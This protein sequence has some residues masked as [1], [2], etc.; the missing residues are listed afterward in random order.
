M[1]R[2]WKCQVQMVWL[3][4][5]SYPFF[6]TTYIDSQRI[7]L[8]LDARSVICI[9]PTCCPTISHPTLPMRSLSSSSIKSRTRMECSLHCPSCMENSLLGPGFTLD[10]HQQEQEPA[11]LGFQGLFPL[12]CI[13][14]LIL[15]TYT[16]TGLSCQCR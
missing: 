5:R 11:I 16:S 4:V 3:Q 7:A 13:N 6:D 8:C 10:L 9:P 14:S 1:R 12:L 2:M 15:F